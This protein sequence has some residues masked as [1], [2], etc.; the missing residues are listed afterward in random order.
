M[1]AKK[2]RSKAKTEHETLK[3]LQCTIKSIE[4]KI[5]ETDKLK[6]VMPVLR[7]V[8][9]ENKYKQKSF[10]FMRRKRHKS[11]FKRKPTVTL[12]SLLKSE[13][14]KS[15]IKSL[16]SQSKSSK[17]ESHLS[18]KTANKV[19][20]EHKTASKSQF[21]YTN[22]R[23]NLEKTY[24]IGN[25]YPENFLYNSQAIEGFYDYQ[26]YAYT[27]YDYSCNNEW[28]SFEPSVYFQSYPQ[29]Y[30]AYYNGYS[31]FS[32]NP[33]EYK[34]V[35]VN[36]ESENFQYSSVVV[37]RKVPCGK[38]QPRSTSSY[39][40][41]IFDDVEIEEVSNYL[42]K[43]ISLNLNNLNK[44]IDDQLHLQILK[45]EENFETVNETKFENCTEDLLINNL[46]IEQPNYKCEAR[47]EILVYDP[48]L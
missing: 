36:N 28:K 25:N 16:E 38:Y 22:D 1:N 41:D 33:N 11:I 4:N 21:S 39:F 13:K 10:R 8:M 27:N 19:K 30:N 18:S 40:K 43:N 48:V 17:D 45:R 2:C 44:L 34:F 23:L 24:T 6:T 47:N 31:S 42:S 32:L 26:N 7:K 3:N 37:C 35:P 46:L 5:L 29:E 14:I 15:Y 9:S 12:K 20:L